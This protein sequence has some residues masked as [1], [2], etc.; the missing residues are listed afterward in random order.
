[1]GGEKIG[2][3]C[4]RNGSE[5]SGENCRRFLKKSVDK[6]FGMWYSI[7]KGDDKFPEKRGRY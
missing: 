7:V 5:E 6:A 4:G 3:P 2:V 1:M